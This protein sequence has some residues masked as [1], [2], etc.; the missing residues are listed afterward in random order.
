MGGMASESLATA[1]KGGDARLS[2]NEPITSHIPCR[3]T[4]LAIAQKKP[5]MHTYTQ[6]AK[7]ERSHHVPQIPYRT[8][9]MATAKQPLQTHCPSE[10]ERQCTDIYIYNK[11][12]QLLQI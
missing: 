5:Y 12:E 7:H 4:S 6:P 3:T 2:T 10:N 11:Y 1:V 9:S 8:T